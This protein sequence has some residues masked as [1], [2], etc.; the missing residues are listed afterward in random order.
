MNIVTISGRLTSDPQI[1]KYSGGELAYFTLA[2]NKKR[3]D[4][5]EES[6]FF[7]IKCFSYLAESAKVLRKGS[8]VIVY[9]ELRQNRYQGDDGKNKEIVEIVA[10]ELGFIS[11]KPALTPP[12]MQETA[13]ANLSFGGESQMNN[14]D[15]I[16]F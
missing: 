16:P 8:P 4:G 3:K 10:N 14:N 9:G 7:T 12:P 5:T 1:I 15:E 6:C 11:K 13:N 2:N